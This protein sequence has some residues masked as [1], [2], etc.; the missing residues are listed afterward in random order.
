MKERAYW[1]DY[2]RAYEDCIGETSSEDCPW[3]IVPADDK[4]DARLI[5][6]QV[7]LET[8]ECLKPQYPRVSEQRRKELLK[9]RK[10][11]EKK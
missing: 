9:L 8:M 1:K 5:I 7:I 3:Y 2:M 10:E 11:L 6:S 4:P